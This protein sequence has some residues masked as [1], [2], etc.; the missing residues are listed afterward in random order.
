MS[1]HRSRLP[2]LVELGNLQPQITRIETFSTVIPQYDNSESPEH[3]RKAARPCNISLQHCNTE[4]SSLNEHNTLE[5]EQ[6]CHCVAM[7]TVLPQDTSNSMAILPHS[8][9]DLGLILPL[10][11]LSVTVWI[12]SENSSFSP[13]PKRLAGWL[14]H[15]N[16]PHSKWAISPFL[17]SAHSVWLQLLNELYP[18]ITLIWDCRSQEN[19][20]P[21]NWVVW[22]GP[23]RRRIQSGTRQWRKKSVTSN[24]QHEYLSIS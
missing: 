24:G 15:V 14:V 23:K 11:A 2:I 18:A 13:T 3:E 1:N 5:P 6:V 9:S 10:G 19:S 16:Y 12:S 7:L 17:F 21:D 20:C 4:S 22:N 8:Y